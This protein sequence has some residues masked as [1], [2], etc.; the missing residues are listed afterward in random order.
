MAAAAM[1]GLKFLVPGMF[2][3]ILGLFANAS[4]DDSIT[5]RTHDYP[6]VADVFAQHP[7]VGRGTGTWFPPKHE[8]FD[9]QY[10][11]TLVEGGVIGLLALIAMLSSGIYAAARSR[12][13]ATDP[14]VRDLALSVTASLTVPVIG[15]ATF[16]LMSFAIVTGLT[17]VMLGASGALLRTARDPAAHS[18]ASDRVQGNRSPDAVDHV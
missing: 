16:D 12:Y 8:T 11:L 3:T 6:I 9:N 10:L 18:P 1:V 15:A 17:F 4:N 13:V 7:W 5:Y 14:Q 2:G